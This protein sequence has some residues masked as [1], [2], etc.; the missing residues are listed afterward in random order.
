VFPGGVAILA[1]VFEALGIDAMTTAQSA[2][3][4]GVIYDLL[5]RQHEDDTR[6]RTVDNLMARFGV[7]PVQARQ[8]RETAISL[9]SQ[10]AMSWRLTS[11]HDKHLIAW[12]ANLHELGMEIS[13]ASY[14]KHG[15]YLIAN[16]DMPGFARPE[17]EQLALLVRTHRRRLPTDTFGSSGDYCLHLAVLLRIS[18]LLHRSRSH[19]P[20]PHIDATAKPGELLLSLPKKWLKGHPLTALDLDKEATYL[21]ALQVS[22]VVKTH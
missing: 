3:R 17:Q 22:L 16:L 10:V 2:L 12:A 18:A 4:E 19:E 14:H 6:D 15:A 13:H 5:G 21:K 7:D 9:L 11:G 1:G 8:V 20:L